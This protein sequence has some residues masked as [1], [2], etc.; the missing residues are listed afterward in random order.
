MKLFFFG[1]STVK[2]PPI[3][4]LLDA[5]AAAEIPK[6]EFFGEL[7]GEKPEAE[8]EEEEEEEEEPLLPKN[9]GSL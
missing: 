2:P 7:F 8:E 6:T 1:F 5:A 9:E 4:P 3:P